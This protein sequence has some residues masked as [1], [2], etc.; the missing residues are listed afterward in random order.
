MCRRLLRTDSNLQRVETAQLVL[1]RLRSGG[2]DDSS[3]DVNALLRLLGNYVA[4]TRELTEEILSLLLFCEN[5][6]L[7]IHHLPKLTYQS[8]ECVELVVQAYLELLSTD[9][10]LLVP[11]LGSLAE[12]PLDISEKNTVVEATQS[13]LDAAV[14]ED[15]PAVV[16]SLL[17][18][19]TKS[20]A[21]K[22]IAR[23]RSEC[24][25]I[26]SGTLSLTME[27]AQRNADALASSAHLFL[28]HLHGIASITTGSGVDG[29]QCRELELL[30]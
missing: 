14:E 8:K 16:Q 30:D 4:P 6:V 24:N 17:S 3:D 29:S 9:R 1:D 12:M 5:R 13:L 11:V 20:S 18:M 25:R 7:L 22:A 23:L 10:S 27:L 19:V 21:P 26:N 2:A 15:I 28:D